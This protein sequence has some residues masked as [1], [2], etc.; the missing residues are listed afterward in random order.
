V[1]RT[2]SARLIGQWLSARLGQSFVV[3]NRL[4]DGLDALALDDVE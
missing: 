2:A 4:Q 3:D 1:I